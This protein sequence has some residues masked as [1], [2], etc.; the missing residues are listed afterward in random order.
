MVILVEGCDGTGKTQLA[1]KLAEELSMPYVHF[2]APKTQE[3]VY[4]QFL[5][6]LKVMEQYCYHVIFDRCWFSE[7][8]YGAIYKGTNDIAQTQLSVLYNIVSKNGGFMIHCTGK[9]TDIYNRLVDRGETPPTV[10]EI[11]KIVNAYKAL[12]RA[13]VQMYIPVIDYDITDLSSNWF[14]PTT[15]E[16][17]YIPIQ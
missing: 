2:V 12:I 13:E 7:E 16:S 15:A 17:H 11:A 4:K 1:K 6:Y 9:P 8:V 3:E 10:D 5:M 14:P